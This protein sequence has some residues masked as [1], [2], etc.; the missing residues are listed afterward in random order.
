M[1]KLIFHFNIIS[2]SLITM[3]N[4]YSLNRTRN[5]QT[6]VI[7]CKVIVRF[8]DIR[9]YI[10]YLSVKDGDAFADEDIR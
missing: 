4:I 9:I 5:I 8:I 2:P 1:L 10:N 7:S 6:S 3:A